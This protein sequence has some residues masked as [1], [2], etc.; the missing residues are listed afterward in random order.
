MSF[1]DKSAKADATVQLILV[2]E[3]MVGKTCILLRYTD[4]SFTHVHMTTIG[5]ENKSKTIQVD[6]K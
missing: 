5:V 2:G 4:D 3:S 1:L 6:D